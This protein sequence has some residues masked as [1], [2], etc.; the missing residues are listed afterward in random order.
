[1]I[2]NSL[3]FFTI[4]YI[5]TWDVNGRLLVRTLFSQNK[6]GDYLD[7]NAAYHDITN[8]IMSLSSRH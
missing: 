6:L 2:V 4:I 7:F 1:M 3:I 5:T 8:K